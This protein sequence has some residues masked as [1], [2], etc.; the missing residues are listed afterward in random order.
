MGVSK[1]VAHLLA[2]AALRV[3]IQISQKYKMG[4]ISKR[5]TKTLSPAKKICKEKVAR[6][7]NRAVG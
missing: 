4:D 7:K 3:R 1:L 6:G 2:T 5:V